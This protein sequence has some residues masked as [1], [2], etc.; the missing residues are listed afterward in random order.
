[1]RAALDELRGTNAVQREMLII[2]DGEETCG[3][4]PV[5]VARA[6]ADGVRIHTISLGEAVSHQLAGIAL[7]TN[8]TY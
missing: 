8:G 5:G 3:E 2:G 1:M 6:E 4:D 7:V